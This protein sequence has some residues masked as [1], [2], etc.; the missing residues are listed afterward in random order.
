MTQSES[1]FLRKFVAELEEW[2]GENA[3]VLTTGEYGTPVRLSLYTDTLTMVL[4]ELD[5]LRKK[6]NDDTSV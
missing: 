5:E 1:T 4:D 3:H 2:E 6:V